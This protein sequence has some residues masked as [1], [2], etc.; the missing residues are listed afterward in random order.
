MEVSAR[1]WIGLD[2][3]IDDSWITSWNETWNALSH[4]PC[5]RNE[6][7][8]P[9]SAPDRNVEVDGNTG[10]NIYTA[11]S[12]TTEAVTVSVMLSVR[13]IGGKMV[14]ALP[15]LKSQLAAFT[16]YDDRDLFVLLKSYSG[17]GRCHP[18]GGSTEEPFPQDNIPFLSTMVPDADVAKQSKEHHGTRLENNGPVGLVWSHGHRTFMA[19]QR[20]DCFCVLVSSE[21]KECMSMFDIPGLKHYIPTRSWVKELQPSQ[22]YLMNYK[23]ESIA[24]RDY[25]RLLVPPEPGNVPFCPGNYIQAL[26]YWQS[27]Y[28]DALQGALTENYLRIVE[29]EGPSIPLQKPHVSQ[30]EHQDFEQQFIA[31][32]PAQ[33]IS[34]KE[35]EKS[36]SSHEQQPTEFESSRSPTPLPPPLEAQSCNT[37]FQPPPTIIIIDEAELSLKKDQKS[38]SME[39]QPSDL[40]ES[41]S[42]SRDLARQEDR[43]TM[44]RKTESVQSQEGSQL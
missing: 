37:P 29:T 26:R 17:T 40:I 23:R 41:T 32:A 19:R 27:S 35:Q 43:P 4:Q 14:A 22:A 31:T 7:E 12:R 30:A 24:D 33:V 1:E 15:N 6:P 28:C 21:G 18:L 10:V 16:S 34:A 13:W 20:A 3:R 9:R 42:E 36:L 39:E 38:G 5:V 2:A 8:V 44:S 25:H 11:S